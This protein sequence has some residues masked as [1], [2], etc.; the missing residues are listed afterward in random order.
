M[1]FAPNPEN[2]QQVLQLVEYMTNA[3]S[4]QMLNTAREKFEHFNKTSSEFSNYLAHIF[5]TSEFS[6]NIRN[7]AGISLKNK[8]TKSDYISPEMHGTQSV[9]IN[10]FSEQQMAHIKGCLVKTLS[11]PSDRLRNTAA[12]I[13][14]SIMR[15]YTVRF[16]PELMKGLISLLQYTDDSRAGAFRCLIMLCEDMTHEFEEDEKDP[17]AMLVPVLI[18]FFDHPDVK[19]KIEA[20]KVYESLLVHFPSAALNNMDNFLNGLTKLV[21]VQD[22][23]IQ[24]YVCSCFVIMLDRPR[25]L[26][27][28]WT[29][30]VEFMLVCTANEKEEQL[31]QEACKFWMTLSEAQALRPMLTELKP[32]LPRLVPIL[33]KG[34]VFSE[35][36]RRMKEED[37]M[38]PAKDSEINPGSLQ[39]ETKVHVI[40]A[41]DESDESFDVDEAQDYLDDIWNLR[42]YSAQSL[43]NM[44]QYFGADI[45]PHLLPHVEN[46]MKEGN[47]WYVRESGVLALGA[48]EKGCGKYLEQYLPQLI[49]YLMSIAA[50]EMALLRSIACWTISRFSD[51]ISSQNEDVFKSILHLFLQCMLDSNKKVQEAAASALCS[52]QE[53]AQTRLVP[54]LP[55]ITDTIA[56]CFTMYKH[57]NLL[58][59]Y[60]AVGTLA[61]AVGEK[62]AIPEIVNK[63]VP[64][65]LQQWHGMEDSDR[66]MHPLMAAITIVSCSVKK[67]MKPYVEVIVARC[68]QIV[69]NNYKMIQEDKANRAESKRFVMSSLDCLS[70]I[71]EA[72][73]QDVSYLLSNEEFFKMLH[74]C[75][76]DP[77]GDVKQVA[78]GV[79]G[80]MAKEHIQALRVGLPK[81]MPILADNLVG[82]PSHVATN[83]AWALGEIAVF[84]KGDY[85]QYLDMTLQ[86][87][88]K[89]LENRK[90]SANLLE[91][92]S[93]AI[94]RIGWVCPQH[95][96]PH[97]ESFCQNWCLALCRVHHPVEKDQA[98]RGL[99]ELV[100]HNNQAAI[101]F[102]PYICEAIASFVSPQDDL[103][104]QMQA[105]LVAVKNAAGNNW[106][107]FFN[108]LNPKLRAFLSQHYQI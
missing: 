89:L 39:M 17:L 21:S 6:S 42:K 24:R 15:K 101:N 10:S 97:L 67:V 58:I 3:Q 102:F 43:D 84:I 54:Y 98:F 100:R 22:T 65:I 90:G 55:H 107:G 32:Y 34:T 85:A 83:S 80:D 64:P 78:F 72:L 53:S 96:S 29:N 94:G 75:L 68:I 48:V 104:Y 81:F 25:Y 31:A 87:L 70:G 56:Q 51:W 27:P 71:I 74:V 61:E 12:N 52:L 13:I 73:G 86:D 7:F 16:W 103:K 91:N 8:L 19:W 18:Q 36:E 26:N 37:S 23:T 5:S 11:D 9:A 4:T 63:L 60:D 20:I 46:Y 41:D 82:V 38:A 57:K 2:L 88:I 76:T 59:L 28:V 45:L 62:L 33:L 66:K 50:K 14:V 106:E 69:H 95:I 40:G 105:I 99:C 1:S 108:Q 49:P 44:S 79:I 47:P 93:V 30:V 92:A 35:F 77:K